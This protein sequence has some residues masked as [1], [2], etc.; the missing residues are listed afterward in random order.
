MTD[1]KF[2]GNLAIARASQSATTDR[3]HVP[4]GE[5][6]CGVAEPA[7]SNAVANVV[8]RRSNEQVFR[9]HASRDVAAVADVHSASNRPVGHLARE[10]VRVHMSSTAVDLRSYT[11]HAITLTGA[12]P[13]PEPTTA[14]PGSMRW[15]RTVLVNLLPE[16]FH[17]V[18][19]HNPAALSRCAI[20]ILSLRHHVT[21]WMLVRPGGAL[22]PSRSH[23]IVAT[24][25][26]VCT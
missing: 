17:W 3:F 18:A 11:E 13:G 12:G 20:I 5:T 23:S 15:L 22:T 14:Y 9:V 24:R 25:A 2:G 19:R 8:T 4:V 7:L 6:C 26:T 16:A 21:S 10:D 1:A